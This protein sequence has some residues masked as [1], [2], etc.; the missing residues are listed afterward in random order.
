MT[1]YIDKDKVAAEI[2]KRA[3][4]YPC[5]NSEQNIGYHCALYEMQDFLNNL[6][7]KEVNLEKELKNLIGNVG[8]GDRWHHAPKELPDC[9]C[10]CLTYYNGRYHINVWNTYYKVWDDSEEGYCEFEST[11]ELDW[12]V[13][14]VQGGNQ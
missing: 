13:L 6:E 5:D 10:F 7:V 14:E 8:Q 11:E 1:K 9:D 3:N 12:I 2:E 4:E